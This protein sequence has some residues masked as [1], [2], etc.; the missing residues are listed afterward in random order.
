MLDGG[1]SSQCDFGGERITASR[2]VH[3]WI[4]V[5]LK[6][7]GQAPP[8]QED[9]PMSKYIVTPSIGVNIRSGPGTGYG[10][11]GAYPMGT[12]VDVLEERG[13]NRSFGRQRDELCE[14]WIGN[15][16][17]CSYHSL[18]PK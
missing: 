15:I 9:K 13:D 4:C 7:A 2:K 1:G 8:E 18:Y 10:K 11:V 12:V 5:Y 6:Q 3:N 16:C 17:G 14:R